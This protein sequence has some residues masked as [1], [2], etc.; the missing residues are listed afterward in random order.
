ATIRDIEVSQGVA[1]ARRAQQLL[2]EAVRRTDAVSSAAKTKF[3]RLRPYQVDA[4]VVPIVVKPDGNPGYPSGH[5][6]AAYAAA[7][8]LAS[9]VPDRAPELLGLAAE[10]GYSRVY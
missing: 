7:L 1:Q 3:G 8:A 10:V 9:F 5:T 2:D 6:S 4:T